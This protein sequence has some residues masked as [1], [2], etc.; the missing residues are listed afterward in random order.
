MAKIEK[1]RIIT[2]ALIGGIIFSGIVTLL[3]YLLGRDFSLMRL[4]FY[5]V[6][7]ILMYGFLTYRNFKKH[8]NGQQ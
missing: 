6:F 3:D 8:N 5:L 1:K 4:L 2:A 7:G